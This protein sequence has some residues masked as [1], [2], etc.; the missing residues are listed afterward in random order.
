MELM[1][2]AFPCKT[3][4]LY[5]LIDPRNYNRLNSLDVLEAKS[6]SVPSVYGTT[7]AETV[8]PWISFFAPTASIFVQPDKRPSPVISPYPHISFPYT[9]PCS[10]LLVAAMPRCGLRVLRGKGYGDQN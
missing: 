8:W 5:N 7:L 10:D 1:C 9:V 6:N 4:D 3:L 2:V